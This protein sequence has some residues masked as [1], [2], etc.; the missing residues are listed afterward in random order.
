MQVAEKLMTIHEECLKGDYQSIE[1]LKE[2][3]S[4]PAVRHIRQVSLVISTSLNDFLLHPCQNIVLRI[5]HFIFVA[6]LSHG[7]QF[8][9][10]FCP[11]ALSF[12]LRGKT[13]M[14]I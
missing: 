11:V 1:K 7:L 6:P 5:I 12:F 13:Q 9:F 2:A 4:R 8:L 10:I 14:Y 3:S